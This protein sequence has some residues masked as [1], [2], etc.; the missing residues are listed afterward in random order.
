MK[1][2]IFSGLRCRGDRCAF[3]VDGVCAV[4]QSGAE[5]TNTIGK[6][7]PVAKWSKCDLHC[8]LHIGGKCIICE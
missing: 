2:C 4:A 7:C 6:Q 8:C 1:M 3:S 5:L